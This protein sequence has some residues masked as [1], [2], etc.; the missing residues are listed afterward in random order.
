MGRLFHLEDDIADDCRGCFL[1]MDEAGYGPNLG[2]LVIA[3]CCWETPTPPASCDLAEVLQRVVNTSSSCR[4][5]KLHIADSKLVNQGKHGFAS[6]ETSALCL[7]KAA[8]IDTASYHT[9]R[10]QIDVRQDAISEQSS[11]IPWDCEDLQLPCAAIPKLID[12]L[13]RRLVAELEE[14]QVTL[15]RFQV[16]LVPALQFNQ[17]LDQHGSKGV[18]LSGL[19]FELLGKIWDSQSRLP[20][21]FVGDKH[22][23]R[24][25]YGDFLTQM[26]Q[27]ATVIRIEER[28]EVSRYRVHSTEFRFQ[29]KGEQHFPVAAASI[30][31]KYLRELAMIQFNSFWRSHLPE[32]KP[33]KGYPLDAKRFH[34]AIRE[35]QERL[36]ICD[37][38]LWRYR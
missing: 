38:Q 8:G 9:I 36:G 35:T 24:N 30:V 1:G 32:I 29:T 13:S 4:G 6:L 2:P 14:K 16:Q 34:I 19:A 12:D 37:Q 5:T 11:S 10:Q 31:A 18:V 21:L 33:T 15:Q 26:V 7:L 22:G 23:G 27:G 20:T 3:S 28:A 17:L 25:K